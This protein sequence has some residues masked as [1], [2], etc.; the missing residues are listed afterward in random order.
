MRHHV[1]AYGSLMFP[2][3]W[4]QVVCAR[5]AARPARL[6]GFE[7]LVVRGETYPAI[8]E[9]VGAWVDGVVYLDVRAG[10]L[11]RLDA[12]E[13][14][15]YERRAL[16]IRL[17]DGIGDRLDAQAYVWTDP[18]RLESCLWDPDWFARDGLPVFLA[19]YCRARGVG[20]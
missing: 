2:Q 10:D 1:F 11:R 20:G 16:P 18:S 6:H 14:A 4:G 15:D 9:C 7:R 5:P 3:V 19:T 8:V 13:G 12:F 17:L